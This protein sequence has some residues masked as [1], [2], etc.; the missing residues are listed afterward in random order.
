MALNYTQAEIDAHPQDFILGLAHPDD[1]HYLYDCVRF[2]KK[3][4]K[5]GLYSCALRLK[6][7]D[8]DYLSL[9]YKCQALSY[10]ADGSVKEYIA[11]V[12]ELNEDEAD[13][14]AIKLR[15]SEIERNKSKYKSVKISKAE[16]EVLKLMLEGET[17]KTI[18]NKL[19]ISEFTV[20]THKT[21]LMNKFDVPN[22]AALMTIVIRY[23]FV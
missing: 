16:M 7:Q 20:K 18:G 11:T 8:G 21:N 10:F 15:I 9:W 3:E 5:Q 1:K 4:N 23:G 22:T 17:S 13:C 6:Q 14:V 12:F 19:N 2:L